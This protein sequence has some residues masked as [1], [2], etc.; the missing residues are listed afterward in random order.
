VTHSG[1]AWLT[2]PLAG[3]IAGYLLFGGSDPVPY[4]EVVIAE[5]ILEREPDTVRT[6]VDRV[7]YRYVGPAR[8]AIAPGGAAQEVA[9]FCRPLILAMVDTVEVESA[10]PRL[11]L[12]SVSHDPGWLWQRDRLTLTGPTSHGD[13]VGLEYA[14][15]PGFSART[16]GDSV[17]VRYPRGSTVRDLLEG[18]AMAY[19]VVAFVR[20]LVR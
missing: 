20:L 2:L 7:V 12:R 8:V 19:G 10:A 1:W 6:F 15:R 13:L 11:L 9:A 14:V 16:S 17:I 4:P 5:R 18:A 3:L